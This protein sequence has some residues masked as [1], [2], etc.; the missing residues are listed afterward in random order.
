[1][2]IDWNRRLAARFLPPV[3]LGTYAAAVSVTPSLIAALLLAFAPLALALCWWAILAPGRWLFLFFTAALLLPPLPIAIGD[4][5]PH[6]AVAV[7]AVGL[8]SGLLHLPDWRISLDFLGRS[9]LIYLLI[10]L[11]SV[12]LAAWYSGPVLAS[13]TAARVLLFAISPYVFFYAR[14]APTDSFRLVRFIYWAAAA[15]ALFACLDFYFQFPAPAGYGPQFVWLASGVYRRAQG[16]F[17]DASA[18]G[19]LCAFFLVMIAVALLRPPSDRPVSR[20]ALL[21]GGAVFSAALIFSYSR[22]SLL[23]L[24]AGVVALLVLERRRLRLRRLAAIVA[25]CA[26]AGT[27]AAYALLPAFVGMYWLRLRMSFEY[28]SSATGA[29]LSGRLASWGALVEFLLQ[30]PWHLLLGVGYKTLPYSSFIGEPV[31]ADNMYLSMLVETGLVGLAALVLLCLAILRASYRAARCDNARASF[32]G[33][34]MF[35]FWTGQLVQMMSQDLLTY[36]RA[37]PVYFC[38][39]ALAMRERDE[40]PVC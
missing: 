3:L 26:A 15:S 40:N 32:F 20:W 35:C 4:S 27:L 39:L 11:G 24:L 31:I 10:L 30:N 34:W 19:N 21:A 25:A 1:V 9:L 2:R 8:F 28:F 14:W 23:N 5:G 6:P 17:Y 38:I 37:L 29:V 22:A 16:L 13:H 18:L 33:T 12:A 36:W 7:A